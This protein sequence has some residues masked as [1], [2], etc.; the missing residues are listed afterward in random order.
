M[1]IQQ[2]ERKTCRLAWATCIQTLPG[3]IT[4]SIYPPWNYHIPYQGT[5]EHCFPRW[6][7]SVPWRVLHQYIPTFP[8]VKQLPRVKPTSA[9]PGSRTSKPAPWCSTNCRTILDVKSVKGW[10]L[11]GMVRL[12]REIQYERDTPWKINMEPTNHPL[13]K[14]HD[15]P[16]LH[17]YMLIFRGL[18]IS[19][20][21]A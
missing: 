20:N 7:T 12:Q 1:G 9:I 16:N 15:L 18:E 10:S 2:Y 11:G 8:N 14:E 6:D 13:R 21:S 4:M 3:S 17:D 19:W 5:L